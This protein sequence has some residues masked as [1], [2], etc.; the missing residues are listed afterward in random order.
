MK[1]LLLKDLRLMKMQKQFFII[2]T[3]IAAGMAVFGQGETFSPFIVAYMTFIGGLFTLST[4]SYDEFDNGN[5]FLFSLPVTRQGYVAEKY[6]FGLITG[7]GFWLLGLVIDIAAGLTR[8]MFSAD[9]VVAALL[10]LPILLLMLAF[11]L[12]FQLKFGGEKGRI[13]MIGAVGIV[14]LAGALLRKIAGAW[15]FHVDDALNNL[16]TLNM[17]MGKVILA[18]VVLAAVLFFVSYKISVS[19]MVRKEF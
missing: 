4:I 1:G 3:V 15:N 17:S 13:A 12:P 10:I 2:I 19:I 5:A 9:T 14:L 6:G 16:E 7:A 8:G 18:V 11:M